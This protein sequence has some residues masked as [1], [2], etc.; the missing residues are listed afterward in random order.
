M[1]GSGDCSGNGERSRSRSG[2]LARRSPG[3]LQAGGGVTEPHRDIGKTSLET[4]REC[5]PLLLVPSRTPQ[6]LGSWHSQN[7]DPLLTQ[8][9]APIPQASA[10]PYSHTGTYHAGLSSICLSHCAGEQQLGPTHCQ[11]K[12][13]GSSVFGGRKDGKARQ[14]KLAVNLLE[15]SHFPCT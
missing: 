15:S 10:Q 2:V 3:R 14:P 7:G 4:G 1:A 6:W 8:G 9:P 11:H 5:C 13:W 12:A